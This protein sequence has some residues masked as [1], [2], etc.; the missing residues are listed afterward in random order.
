MPVILKDVSHVYS[1]GTPFEVRALDQINLTINDGDFVGLI[2]QTG[3]GKSTL[4]Q[5]INGLLKPT[6][7]SVTVN[8]RSTDVRGAA[9]R[10]L[11]REVGLVFQY[12][13]YQLFEETVSADVA[14][15]PRQLGLPEEEIQRRTTS[16]LTAVGLD[17]VAAGSRSPFELSGGQMRR[18]AIAG[19]LAMEPRVL[20]LDEPTAGLDPE[21]RDEILDEIAKWWR[22]NN[23]TV[24]LVTHNM[25]DIARL[26]TRLIVMAKG[27]V[28]I[29][30]APRDVFSRPA[31]IRT[32]GLRLP[33]VAEVA[34]LLRDKGW[35][36]AKTPLTPEEAAEQILL[37]IRQGKVNGLVP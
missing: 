23:A 2:G 6:S 35:P 7:G 19:V 15:G 21:G 10:E 20:I 24:I 32:Q 13:E 17:P 4:I 1:A 27:R 14:F 12:P 33:Q 26:A 30:A 36:I 28:V 3:S 5:H 11:R 37:A 16:A 25:E 8:G 22:Q 31:E 29:D 9:I 18:V 34:R